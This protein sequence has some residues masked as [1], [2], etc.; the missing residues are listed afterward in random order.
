MM[1]KF[2][3]G[4]GKDPG[5]VTLATIGGNSCEKERAR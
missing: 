2:G 1:A 5:L 3:A 4:N